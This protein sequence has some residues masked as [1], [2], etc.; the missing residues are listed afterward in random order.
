MTASDRS[1]GSEGDL[2][3]DLRRE[4]TKAFVMGAILLIALAVVAA[5]FV[6]FGLGGAM[7][8][9]LATLLLLLA[10][11]AYC[12]RLVTTS[13]PEGSRRRLR[14]EVT[15]PDKLGKEVRGMS[16]AASGTALTL[17]YPG[18]VLVILSSQF[19]RFLPF[20]LLWLVAWASLWRNALLAVDELL[21]PAA[22]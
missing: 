10:E 6:A 8:P 17:A 3:R 4:I 22:A 12:A 11:G 1:E 19:W 7:R 14:I 15:S 13:R 16:C 20:A 21:G 18:V 9:N 5:I 2:R